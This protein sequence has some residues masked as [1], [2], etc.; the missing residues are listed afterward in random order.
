MRIL[1]LKVRCFLQGR[2]EVAVCRFSNK[3]DERSGSG[4][5]EVYDLQVNVFRL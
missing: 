2:E 3:S 4:S 5:G 1:L